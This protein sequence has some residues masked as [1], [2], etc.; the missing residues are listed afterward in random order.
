M[1]QDCSY[2]IIPMKYESGKWFVFL[3]QQHQGHWCFP[4]GHAEK[5]ETAIQAASREL[6]EETHLKV[7]RFLDMSSF[8]ESFIFTFEGVHIH[9]EVTYFAAYVSGE[10]ILQKEEVLQGDWFPTEAVEERLSFP[11]AKNIAKKL[12]TLLLKK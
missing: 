4:K 2:G 9:K 6:Y 3:I 5:G 7:D 12:I 11:E 8:K 1:K 10:V